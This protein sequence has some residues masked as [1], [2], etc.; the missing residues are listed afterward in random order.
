MGSPIGIVRCIG[1]SLLVATGCGDGGRADDEVGD[2]AGTNGENGEANT[3]DGTSND[4]Q[5]TQDGPDDDAEQGTM[6]D[7]SPTDDS[8]TDDSPDDDSG[9][10]PKFDLAPAPD[11]AVDCQC[12]SQLGF[13][14]IWIANSTQGTVTKLNTETMVEEGR[15]LT[16]ADAGG[17][18]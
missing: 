5:S 15:Y 9:M 2:A 14:Y 16:R 11:S 8:P 17:S 3:L 6:T 7:D 4:E 1:V 13:S 18:P 10:L 12:G